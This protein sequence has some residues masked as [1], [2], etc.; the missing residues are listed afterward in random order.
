MKLHVT[1]DSDGEIHVHSE[2]EREIAYAPGTTDEVLTLE[3][4]GIVDVEAHELDQLIVK[5][6]VS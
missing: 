5:L 6:E 3:Q 4:P 1:A 2:P